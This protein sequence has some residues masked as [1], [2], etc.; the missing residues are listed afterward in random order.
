MKMRRQKVQD[1]YIVRFFSFLTNFVYHTLSV[2]LLGRIFT[3]Y[4]A[5][6]KAFRNSGAGRLV[7]TSE[8]RSGKLYHAF[9]RNVALAMSHS[10]I[11]NGVHELIRRICRCS[12]RT[13]GLFL[14]TSGAYSAIMYWLFSVVWHN[15]AVEILNLYCGICVLIVGI[16]LLFSDASLGY[17]LQKGVFFGKILV[18][19]LGVSDDALRDMEKTG[20]QAYVIAVPSGMVLGAL[21]SLISPFYLIVG[22]ALLLW[23]LLVLSVP[24]SG[25][26]L[27]I[28]FLPFAGLLPNADMW[29]VSATALPLISY[30]LKLLRGN[31]TMHVEVQDV[32]VL[33]MVVLFALSGF[34]VAGNSAFRGALLSALFT[35]VYFLVVNVIATPHWMTRC[36]VALIVSA[37]AAAL[38]GIFQFVFAAVSADTIFLPALGASVHAGFADRTTFAYFL[39]VAF[40]FVFSSFIHAKKQYRLPV[41]FAMVSVLAALVLTWVQSAWLA[42]MTILVVFFLLYERRVFPFVLVGGIL[43]PVALAVLPNSVRGRLLD[44]LRVDPGAILVGN[45]AGG[46]ASR[47]VSG[48]GSAFGTGFSR[49][50]F[51]LGYGGIEQICMLYTATAPTAI[52][53]SLGFWQYRLLEGGVLGVLVPAAFLF[54]LCQN[55]FSLLRAATAKNV[56]ISAITGVTLVA[57]VLVLS[58]FRYAWYDAAALLCFF[59]AAALIT[60]DARYY[61]SRETVVSE[62]TTENEYAVEM[63]Y[64]GRA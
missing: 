36:R 53:G 20:K 38:L 14:V 62:D 13:V 27:L 15:G 55:C 28:L 63:E 49:V 34:S 2:G 21:C 1:S 29:L 51:G 18:G 25:V 26:A 48:A 11:I 17:T 19:A 44:I 31:R 12:L 50:M 10:V 64:Y 59:I 46:V 43:T 42:V 8:R 40:P 24:E 58:L 52:S 5:T 37:T 41:G 22:I 56:Q 6:N 45:G 39:V 60:A 4:T 33:L 61:R 32:P 9:R 54:L 30:L 16:L 35:G 7:H 57:G 23:F 3:A 47:I